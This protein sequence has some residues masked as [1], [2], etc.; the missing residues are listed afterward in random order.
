MT[1]ISPG[2]AQKYARS[3]TLCLQTYWKLLK[4]YDFIDANAESSTGEVVVRRA[5]LDNWTKVLNDEIAS[6]KFTLLSHT[7]IAILKRVIS[8][9]HA[10]DDSYSG[11]PTVTVRRNELDLE[12]MPLSGEALAELEKHKLIEPI[13]K[14]S[15][16]VEVA[17]VFNAFTN[18]SLLK[19]FDHTIH[20][21]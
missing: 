5:S 14:L 16:T 3:A 1:Q 9:L 11:N 21:V 2:K 4:E 15:F 19:Y 12:N 6:E 13:D 20:N 18:Q 10:A 7:S 17:K 8:H